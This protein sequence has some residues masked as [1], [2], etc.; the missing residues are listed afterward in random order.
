MEKILRE[1]LLELKKF[2]AT[3]NQD[4]TVDAKTAIK[5]L[6][7]SNPRDMKYIR[8]HYMTSEDFKM[9]NNKA[10]GYVMRRLIELKNSGKALIKN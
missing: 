4:T 1:I 6:G 3:M 7:G 10:F 5:I 8:E 2:N 9:I